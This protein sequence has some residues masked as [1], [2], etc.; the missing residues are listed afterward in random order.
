MRLLFSSIQI[1]KSTS[2][3]RPLAVFSFVALLISGPTLQAQHAM[4]NMGGDSDLEVET[5][6][7]NN[8]VLG[9]QPENLML[10]FGPMVRL[11]K[12]AIRTPE[13]EL[14][15]I[16]F[17]YNPEAGHEFMHRLPRLQAADYYKVEW[18]VLD[19]E[20]SLI[21]GDFHFAFGENARPPSY[22]LDQ[23]EQMQHIMAPDYRLLGPDS[24]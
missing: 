19:S 8:A 4:H 5:M 14:L 15:D 9:N 16:G 3:A 11:V 17:R 22:Y 10:H 1:L 24:Q 7:A 23:M 18:A 6:P 12:L 2:T 20:D 21:K 13:S